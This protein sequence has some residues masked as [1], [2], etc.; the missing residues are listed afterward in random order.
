V[1]STVV[2]IQCINFKLISFYA[3]LSQC[4]VEAMPCFPHFSPFYFCHSSALHTSS[5][6]NSSLSIVNSTRCNN[7]PF[8]T[9]TIN[10]DHSSYTH[11]YL[12]LYQHTFAPLCIIKPATSQLHNLCTQYPPPPTFNTH[13]TTF[14]LTF[15]P[16]VVYG[17]FHRRL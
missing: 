15:G 14:G 12:P 17:N 11:N 3:I 7:F 1:F 10:L 6:F 2:L 4:D 9:L 13:L 16:S 5:H 8:L